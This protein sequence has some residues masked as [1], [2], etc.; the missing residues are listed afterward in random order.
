MTQL[1]DNVFVYPIPSMAFGIMINNYG[2]ESELMYM[3]SMSDIA[4]GD[5]AEETLITKTLP[6]GSYEFL[7]TTD[8]ATEEQARKVTGLQHHNFKEWYINFEGR[9]YF[10]EALPSLRSLMRSKGCEGEWAVV[11]KR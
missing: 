2:T 7:F 10:T 5:N 9:N 1:T 11:R 6:P 8:S 4:D 3:L